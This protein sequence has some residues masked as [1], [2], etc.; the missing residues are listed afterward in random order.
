MLTV[1]T[2]ATSRP[3]FLRGTPDEETWEEDGADEVEART[4][5]SSTPLSELRVFVAFFFFLHRIKIVQN[6][7]L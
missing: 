1:S 3:R 5:E 2:A 7:C 4:S 6:N